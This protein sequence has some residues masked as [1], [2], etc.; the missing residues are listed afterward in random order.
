MERR[1]KGREIARA[2]LPFVVLTGSL[3]LGLVG[4]R[5][6]LDSS[7][8]GIDGTAAA[9]VAAQRSAASR[10]PTCTVPQEVVRLAMTASSPYGSSYQMA[11]GSACAEPVYNSSKY[12]L[13]GMFEPGDTLRPDCLA[14]HGSSTMLSVNV[15]KADGSD[16]VLH[17]YLSMSDS[18]GTLRDMAQNLPPCADDAD[19]PGLIR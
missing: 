7:L 4:A 17:G 9:A 1:G 18:P 5:A 3:V 12:V 2:G 19:T 6:T 14:T 8:A 16:D 11:P 10:Y 15:D 13:L